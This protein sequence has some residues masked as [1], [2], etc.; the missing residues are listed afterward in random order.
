VLEEIARAIGLTITSTTQVRDAVMRYLRAQAT[1]LVIDSC[2][3]A[4]AA[5]RER[6]RLPARPGMRC[7]R[8]RPETLVSN[9]AEATFSAIELFVWRAYDRRRRAA[10]SCAEFRLACVPVASAPSRSEA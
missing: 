4:L 10:H 3:H 5:S 7:R 1:L 9:A 2:E 8:C 6:M